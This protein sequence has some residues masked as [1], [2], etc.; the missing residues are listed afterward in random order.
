VSS[1]YVITSACVDV[2]DAS[3]VEECPV[4]CIHTSDEDRICYIDPVECIGCDK[5]LPACP[6]GAIYTADRAPVAPS[7]WVEVNALWFTDPAAARRR[8]DELAPR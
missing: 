4:A 1:I 7:A 2:K 6:V 8:V 5:C 3:C